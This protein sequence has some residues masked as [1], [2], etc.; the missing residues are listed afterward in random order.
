MNIEI[1]PV[2]SDQVRDGITFINSN[3]RQIG[4]SNQHIDA[5]NFFSN[6]SNTTTLIERAEDTAALL[7]DVSLS[8]P[9]LSDIS[10]SEVVLDYE[11]AY[12]VFERV[13]LLDEATDLI[14]AYIHDSDGT[15]I[16][17][18][19]GSIIG[20]PFD[21]LV[22]VA[23]DDSTGALDLLKTF[24][25]SSAYELSTIVE[26]FPAALS[27]SRATF[28]RLPEPLE[29]QF[30]DAVRNFVPLANEINSIEILNT[31][32]TQIAP[33]L[34]QHLRG[35]LNATDSAILLSDMAALIA[36]IEG[37]STPSTKIATGVLKFSDT[38][39]NLF[40]I[41]QAYA[42]VS[43]RTEPLVRIAHDALMLEQG[44]AMVEIIQGFLEIIPSGVSTTRTRDV[45]EAMLEFVDRVG[46]GSQYNTA[47]EQLARRA[48]AAEA[49]ADAAPGL[50]EALDDYTFLGAFSIIGGTATAANS[51]ATQQIVYDPA[52]D[53]TLADQ[54]ASDVQ[55][56]DQ[57]D[58]T[59]VVSAGFATTNLNGSNAIERLSLDYSGTFGGQRA[60]GV[61]IISDRFNNWVT[62]E[63][64]S[65]SFF[66]ILN[67]EKLSVVGSDGDDTLG[68][69]DGNDILSG[70]DGN[71]TL[72]GED[73]NDLLLGGKDS[74]TMLGGD[75]ND[76]LVG[77]IGGD[78]LDGGSGK[79]IAS[80]ADTSVGVLVDLVNTGFNT[81]FAAGDSYISIEV[82]VGSG[83][84]DDIRGDAGN[85]QLEGRNGDDFITGRGGDDDLRG[86]NGN[87]VIV[88]GTGGD[89]IFGGAGSDTASYID[90]ASGLVVDLFSF[91]LNTGI[92]AGDVY[93][94]VE[95]SVGSSSN[96]DMRGN[97]DA[98]RIEGRDGS[99]F[100]FGRGG[101]D[102]MFG[103][104]GNDNLRGGSGGDILNGGVGTDSAN[105]ID[106]AGV[107]ADLQNAAVNNGI[108]AGDTYVSVENLFGSNG[109]DDLRGDGGANRL[110]G[111]DGN[112]FL[113]GR[114]GNDELFGGNGDDV[115]R[116]GNGTDTLT[117]NAGDDVFRFDTTTEGVD[118]IRDFQINRDTI[119]L[120]DAGFSS[121]STGALSADNFRMTGT[122]ADADD[123]IIYDAASGAL[124]YDADG[125][126]GAAATRF[127]TLQNT[128][129][130]DVE[131]FFVI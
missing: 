91:G 27:I 22:T 69:G 121:L 62:F 5:I 42:Q 73:G 86:G 43:E 79:D 19:Q 24:L 61:Q 78:T 112:D 58:G 30:E 32:I 114:D 15:V 92:A 98:N 72:R 83:Y 125:A 29:R 90:S 14:E 66:D 113:T 2:Y 9:F 101:N 120:N 57:G 131:D 122:A 76:V 54:S 49:L 17:L 7:D 81:G 31:V 111:R 23:N 52:V 89:R 110:I 104:N 100:L 93:S 88:G 38:K 126:G 1:I 123:Y 47:Y 119:V 74:D 108:A 65:R 70:G 39:D 87:D 80:Y 59:L 107:R 124:F 97:N 85:N 68:G 115:L 36:Q 60:D 21:T 55:V 130:I 84:V 6:S 75:D 94:G 41:Q 34:L 103:G 8:R 95:N 28:L 82:I 50:V 116:G 109:G 51:F 4:L 129:A 105:Y 26:I 96:D 48:E 77:G 106:S 10:L 25:T 99:D 35:D 20:E 16:D 118:V 33:K 67:F 45:M 3:F 127:A 37:F 102:T 53:V 63:D 46:I 40:A 128:A 56:I 13:A 12:G 44:R 18:D 117:G 64:G 71:D 11:I